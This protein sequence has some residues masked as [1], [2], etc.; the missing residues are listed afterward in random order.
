MPNKT[1]A[2]KMRL[3]A[4]VI[5][6]M[7]IIFTLSSIPGKE[8]PSVKIPHLDKIVHSIEYFILGF[9]LIRAFS[10]S[11]TGVNRTLLVAFSIF[12]AAGFAITDELHQS[13]IPGRVTDIIDFMSDSM[14]SAVGILIYKKKQN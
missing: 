12:I 5:L 7:I 1:P 13:F 9:L 11:A 3:W 14:G 2:T 6:W 8:I 4:P 10:N